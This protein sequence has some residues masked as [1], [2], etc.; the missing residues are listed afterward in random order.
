MKRIGLLFLAAFL[1]ASPASA[2]YFYRDGKGNL[3]EIK[4]G[5]VAGKVIPYSSLIDGSATP[6]GTNTNPLYV[7]FPSAQHVICDSGCSGGG[8][9][10]GAVY[11]PTAVGVAAAN[12]PVLIGGTVDGTA[13]GAM[14]AWKVLAGVGFINC[15]NCS[16]SG[17]SVAYAGPIGSVGTPGGFRDASGNFQPLLGDVVAGQWVNVKS[18]VPLA[19]TGTFWQA[20]QPVSIAGTVTVTGPLTD[21]QLRATPVPV[22]GTFWQATQPVSIAAT[23]NVAG[24]LTDAQLRA[25]AVPVSLSSTTITGSVTV[26]QA[27]A[28]S[29]NAT[30]V[31]TG[32][33]A[34]Q[35]APSSAAAWGVNT[36]GSTT[37]GQSG[38]LALGAVTTAAPT[39]TTAQSNA[40]S[41]TTAGALRVDGSAVTQPVSLTSTTITG[42]VAVTQSGTWTVQPGNTANTTAWLVTGTGG[43]FPATQSGTWNITNISG[44][45]SLPTGAATGVA[46]GSTTSGQVGTLAQGAVATANPTYT[47]GQTSPLSI[48]TSGG[49]RVSII[50]GGGSGG[51]ASSFGA[52]FPATGT[53]V[54]MSQGGN[55]VAFTGTSGNLNVQCANCSG[56]GASATDA[57]A[58]TA[59][60][61]VLAP[62][63]GFF[64]TTATANALT[65][66]Q[67]GMWQMTAN[68]AGFVNLR[69]TSGTAIGT[70]AAELFVGGR[71]TA[72]SAAGG[73]LSVQGVASM[74]PLLANPGTA[75]LWAINTIGSTTSGQSGVLGLGA[76]TT[77]APTYTTAQS[78]PL[79]L[80]TAGDLRTVFSN[81]SIAV[82]QASAASL[83]ATVVGTGT[84]AVQATLAAETTKVIG[85]VNVAAGQT[86]AVTNAGTFA[87]QAASATAPVSTMNSASANAG[88]NVA[89]AAVFDDVSPTAI[90]ENNFGFLRMSANR[91]LYGTI[92]DAAGNERGANVDS[93]NRLTTAPTLVSGSVASGAFASGSIASGALA[94]G[95]IAAGAMVDLL[96]M[97][98]TVAAGTAASNSLLTGAI[99]NS[100]PITV[101]NGQGAALQSDAN[102]F[103]KVN[104]ATAT[105]LAAGSTT[106][107]QTGSI[108]MCAVTTSAPT[109]TTG[110]TNFL[111]CDTSG[112]LRTSGGGG[113]GG[114]VT[115]ASGAVASGAYSSGSIASGAFASGAVSSGAYASG[116]LASGAVVDLTNLSTPI[117]PTTATATKG[118][119]LGGQYNST[120]A[121][122]TNGQQG[123]LQISSRGAQYVAVGADGFNVTNA[124]TFATQSAQSGTWNITNISG[125]ISLPTGA[126]TG[127]AQA[128]TTSGQVGTLIQGAVTTASPTYTTAQ[129][130]PLSL[131]TSGSLRVNCITGCGGSGGTASNFG[132][133]F[134]TAGTAAGF[135]N[136]TNMVAAQVGDVNNVAAA[137]NYLDTLT[138][139][140]YNATQPTLTD[141]RFS[142][143]Q[144]SSRGE[145]LVAPGVSGF[146]V[147]NA[148]TF[149]VQIA[150]NSSVNVAQI[151]GV[152]PLM[153]N[154]A[155]GTGSQRVTIAND[156]SAIGGKGE[157]ATGATVPTGAVLAGAQS[158]ANMVALIQASAS[159]AI[160][161]ST[162]TTTQLVALSG[163]TKIYVT[164]YDVIAGGTGNI[165]FVYG[166]G[167][168]CGTGTTSL[169]GAYNLTAQAGIAKGGGLGPVLV[170]PAGNALCVTTSAAV[171]MSGSIAYT[172]F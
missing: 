117:T 9:G 60:A 44:T 31:G 21:T 36:L 19:V 124:G 115:M 81:T 125:T 46:Q 123:A 132:S 66:G 42:T 116:S 65:N 147:T 152:T 137:T 33:F 157:G 128:S 167:S 51:T 75:S 62:G 63:G 1:F 143:V 127:V 80:T 103:L 107:G 15:A 70:S 93:S 32:T 38:Q 119:L 71:G 64:Q 159:A 79:S 5:T 84:F 134:P 162:A 29:L 39:Y 23:V 3:I 102:G 11:G 27:S 58:F 68:R 156:S 129:T 133:T 47:N 48:D 142:S 155:T 139:G 113:G 34:V 160:N 131:D 141:T 100:T 24:P 76:V 22:S 158:G 161:V 86:I 104:V 169:T 10:G 61:S 126:A 52:A 164:S 135:T 18:S 50:A 67:Q 166:T 94:S 168:N 43:T 85:T 4:A 73:V 13:T 130:S 92:R 165:T 97:R 146:N 28:A 101:A 2:D 138:I 110:Q 114:A 59:G 35:A 91:N 77:S 57:T 154:G 163:S 53:A 98:G 122:F 120:Q 149:A 6:V 8:G 17:I 26:A 140:R 153:G 83:N 151:N 54:G 88:L 78:N 25:T 145:L 89:N 171:Q 121:T 99:Y 108:V 30:V 106:S 56:S 90:T 111:S 82:T 16:G 7:A 172:Q 112:N 74:T 144:L 95:S 41:L 87:V 55:M 12:P 69:D 49:L 170:V 40:L 72:G 105:G 20:T 148:G 136:G 109:Y 150:A 118:I 45:V 14:S 37:S 96:T